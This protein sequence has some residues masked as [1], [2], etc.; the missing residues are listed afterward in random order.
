MVVMVRAVVMLAVGGTSL[1]LCLPTLTA[2]LSPLPLVLLPVVVV[3]NNKNY[4][5]HK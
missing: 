4:R 3:V 5:K 2:L 1:K